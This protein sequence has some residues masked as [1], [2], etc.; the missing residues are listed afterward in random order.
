MDG[1]WKVSRSTTRIGAALVVAGALSVGASACGSGSSTDSASTV[2]KQ[3]GAAE[4]GTEATGM[5]FS[6][7]NSTKEAVTLQL[8]GDGDCSGEHQLQPDRL[9]GVVATDVKGSIVYQDG[10]RQDFIAQNPSPGEPYIELS[11][12]PGSPFRFQLSEGEQKQFG[13]GNESSVANGGKGNYYYTL[14]RSPDYRPGPDGQPQAA[15]GGDVI[16]SL[17]IDGRR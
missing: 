12:P 5:R 8:C 14:K 17:R 16:M 11:A 7:D 2:E 4:P 15:P 6:V 3:A 1:S 13:G 10:R 9:D